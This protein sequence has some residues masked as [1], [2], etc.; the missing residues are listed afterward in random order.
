MPWAARAPCAPASLYESPCL[1]LRSARVCGSGEVIEWIEKNPKELEE[2]REAKLNRTVCPFISGSEQSVAQTGYL[3]GI[4]SGHAGRNIRDGRRKPVSWLK[5][6]MR[7][8]LFFVVM[9]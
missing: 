9:P 8:C 5:S 7:S 1:D 4:C 2:L 6:K 3:T